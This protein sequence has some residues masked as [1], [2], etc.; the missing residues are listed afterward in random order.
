MEVRWVPP[1]R[2][3][4]YLMSERVYNDRLLMKL[5]EEEE[6]EEAKRKLLESPITF[7]FDYKFGSGSHLYDFQKLISKTSS[8]IKGLSFDSEY[9]DYNY[10]FN[11]GEKKRLEEQQ[12]RVIVTPTNAKETT[13]SKSSKESKVQFG[14]VTDFESDPYE[15]R[16][17]RERKRASSAAKKSGELDWNDI[18]VDFSPDALDDL[19]GEGE[20]EGSNLSDLL[21]GISLQG[22]TRKRGSKPSKG[23][24]KSNSNNSKFGRDGSE[25]F[26][27]DDVS[28]YFTDK[29]LSD[30]NEESEKSELKDGIS[31]LGGAHNNK[32]CKHVPTSSTK[33]RSEDYY[34]KLPRL[35]RNSELRE[36]VVASG[37]HKQKPQIQGG[38][39]VTHRCMAPY[40][41][42]YERALALVR[43]RSLPD[44]SSHLYDRTTRLTF[45]YIPGMPGTESTT[46]DS[47]ARGTRS[48]A[49]KSTVHEGLKGIL[50]DV[51]MNDFYREEDELIYY[52]KN[53]D[54]NVVVE[55]SVDTLESRTDDVDSDDTY[56][57]TSEAITR[58]TSEAYIL[59][60]K[61]SM[62]TDNESTS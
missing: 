42:A 2:E 47:K 58:A 35:L 20:G 13:A 11:E 30:E 14:D 10:D 15:E 36:K 31:E 54:L 23:S 19:L 25:V 34:K 1:R 24:R 18:D 60:L 26:S 48:F 29:S 3:S 49:M 50:G 5:R 33:K 21:G 57:D 8:D 40:K 32:Y 55:S 4:Y 28:T 51:N 27:I 17:S 45:S 43:G 22:T 53:D 41:T 59:K 6:A 56:E 37:R 9:K 16:L 12:G 61:S 38:P 39:Y 46:L 44:H 7:D 62:D 52:V